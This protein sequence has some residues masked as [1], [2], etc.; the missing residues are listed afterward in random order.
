MVSGEFL[1]ALFKSQSGSHEISTMLKQMAM[2]IA[3]SGQVPA[4]C[5]DIIQ[6]LL[7]HWK[8]FVF[9]QH[10]CRICQVIFKE[11]MYWRQ[12]DYIIDNEIMGHI[13]QL[14]QEKY[15]SH[16]IEI[17]IKFSSPIYLT[18]IFNEILYGYKPLYEPEAHPNAPPLSALEVIMFDQ[19]GNYVFQHLY[20]AA[21]DV[22]NSIR[23][24]DARWLYMLDCA[25]NRN[26]HKLRRLTHG[27]QILKSKHF[28]N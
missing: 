25:I 2:E 8:E 17:A 12:R 21:E 9:D 15:G 14:S 20:R 24:G 4:Y 27:R 11:P 16:I 7:A 26:H 18:K 10:A 19:F 1:T 6:W 28:V 22:R 3:E 23:P 13:V 5:N